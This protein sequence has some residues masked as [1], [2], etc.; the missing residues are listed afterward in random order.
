MIA[1]SHAAASA[2]RPAPTPA[3]LVV[4]LARAHGPL[5]LADTDDTATLRARLRAAGGADVVLTPAEEAAYHR[6]AG[7]T[8]AM[9]TSSNPLDR[10]LYRA[11]DRVLRESPVVS[12]PRQQPE[13]RSRPGCGGPDSSA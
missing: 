8:N 10:W 12:G 6:L 2:H 3:A 11:L 13:R 7:R 9:W 5:D 4:G 1:G